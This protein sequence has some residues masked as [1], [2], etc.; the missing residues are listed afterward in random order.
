MAFVCDEGVHKYVNVFVPPLVIV[1]VAV[2]VDEP[3]HNG[4]VPVALGV[5]VKVCAPTV[6]LA[7]AVQVLASVTVT[8]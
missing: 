2:P 4:F 5:Q 6:P 8:E 3:A 7:V 1:T